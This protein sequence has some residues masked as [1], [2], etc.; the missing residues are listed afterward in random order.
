MSTLM[1]FLSLLWNLDVIF[2]V[3]VIVFLVAVATVVYF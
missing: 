1:L 2:V 3:V